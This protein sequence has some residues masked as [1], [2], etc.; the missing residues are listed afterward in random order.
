MKKIRYIL[1]ALLLLLATLLAACTPPAEPTDLA[2]LD[3]GEYVS[4]PK[5]AY[6]GKTFKADAQREVTDGDVTDFAEGIMLEYRTYDTTPSYEGELAPYDG[7]YLWFRMRY[8]GKDIE[9][10]C[11]YG[12]AQGMRVILCEGDVPPEVE[13]A[14]IGTLVES[15]N[16]KKKSGT[17]SAT[18]VVAVKFKADKGGSPTS[19]RIDLAEHPDAAAALVGHATGEQVEMT[20]GGEKGLC[21]IGG[22]VEE[23][24]MLSV[25]VELPT[26]YTNIPT[27]IFLN[28]A[29]VEFLVAAEAFHDVTIP[30]EFNEDFI[31]NVWEAPLTDAATGEP[32]RGDALVTEHLRLIREYLEDTVE[33]QYREN[34]ASVFTEH[35]VAEM[36]VLQYPEQI[37]LECIDE[38]WAE[39]RPSYEAE[40]AFCE[41]NGIDFPYLTVEEYGKNYWNCANSILYVEEIAEEQLKA[42]MALYYVAQKEGYMPSDAAVEEEFERFVA[43]GIEQY[44]QDDVSATDEELREYL[45]SYYGGEEKLKISLREELMLASV[46]DFMKA[47]NRIDS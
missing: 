14:L 3:L 23:E 34:L 21:W 26:D 5:S 11:N 2:K 10:Q 25:E 30:T 40:K 4:L 43:E 47:N 29:T 28:G 31:L 46:V 33:S 13:N 22:I 16:M 8:Q 7:I 32:L 1:P 15:Y 18:D 41:K 17:V 42:R 12:D 44:R 24:T 37:L 19:L 36:E 35:L 39:V 6:T 20:W 38:I 45:L 9:G 27:L